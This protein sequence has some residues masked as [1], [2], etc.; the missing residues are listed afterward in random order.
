MLRDQTVLLSKVKPFH[1]QR[2]D[3]FSCLISDSEAV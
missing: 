1:Y 3:K 2:S